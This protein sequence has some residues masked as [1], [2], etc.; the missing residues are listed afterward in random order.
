[1]VFSNLFDRYKRKFNDK[2]LILLFY[3][4]M[5]ILFK[6]NKTLH[7]IFQSLLLNN[8]CAVAEVEANEASDDVDVEEIFTADPG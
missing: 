5:L 7:N 3:E 8:C 6:I 2:T 4:H 1:V